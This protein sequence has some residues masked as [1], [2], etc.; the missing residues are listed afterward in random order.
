MK[1]QMRGPVFLKTWLWVVCTAHLCWG[2]KVTACSVLTEGFNKQMDT[3][4][5]R[6]IFLT[7]TCISSHFSLVT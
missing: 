1:N 4:Q 7:C 2:G 6:V 5:L 3:T